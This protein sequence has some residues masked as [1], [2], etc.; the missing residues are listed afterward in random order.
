MPFT[1]DDPLIAQFEVLADML[2]YHPY[3]RL[4][5]K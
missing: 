3:L 5:L 2:E 1:G 4:H